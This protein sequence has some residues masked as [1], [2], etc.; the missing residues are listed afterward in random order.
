LIQFNQA[1]LGKWLW[2]FAK[3]R[4]ALWRLVIEVKY[5]SLRGGWC[6]AEVVGSYG[7]RVWKYI[8]RGWDNFYKFVRLEVGDGYN[9]QF[10][11]DLWCGDRPLKLC[12]PAL[13]SV[14]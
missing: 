2:R 10:W 12:Y 11:H 1:L 8:G 13:F 3:E 9:V 7:V 4:E 6:S 5:G 14:V